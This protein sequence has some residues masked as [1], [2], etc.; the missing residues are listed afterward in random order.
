MKYYLITLFLF[1]GIT[2]TVNA[3]EESIG[4]MAAKKT[5][6]YVFPAKGQS[7]EQLDADESAC[8]KWAVQQSGV[9]PLNPPQ[10][11]AA[12]VEHGPDGSRVVGSAR[13]AAGGAAIGAIFGHA[14]KGAAAGAVAGAF[15]S[16]REKRMEEKQQEG[17]N[18]QAAAQYSAELID[19]FK[20]AFSACLEGKG[21]TVK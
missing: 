13:G 4:A 2:S 17:A 19:N 7:N 8:Y 20:K 12:P 10:V 21:Y 16:G 1:V 11:Q 6:V 9:D 3:Q 15:R 5:G 14:G 18:Q